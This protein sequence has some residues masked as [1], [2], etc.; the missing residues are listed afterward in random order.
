VQQ[1]HF[2]QYRQEELPV[3]EERATLTR[4]G[5]QRLSEEL[6]FLRDVRRPE[7]AAALEQ[8][9]ET[10]LSTEAE[11]GYELAKEEQ[12]SLETRILEL[13]HTLGN[14]EIIDEQAAHGSDTVRL[15][16]TVVVKGEDGKEQT[17]HIV[18]QLEVNPLRGY[19]SDESPVGRALM[20]HRMGDTVD[21]EVPNGI[22]RLQV[23]SLK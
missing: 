2:E 9:R 5:F 10:N 16:S 8:A 17:V 4:E 12:A 11:P 19:I 13:E 20:G 23:V 6:A 7:V 18:G 3:A 15:G 21:V 1:Y 22:R 14:A